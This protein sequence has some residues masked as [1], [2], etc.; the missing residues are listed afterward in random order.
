MQFESEFFKLNLLLAVL[1][2]D[3]YTFGRLPVPQCDISVKDKL[4]PKKEQVISKIHFRICRE[5][6]VTS[7]GFEDDVVYLKDE[8]ANGTFV[9]GKVVGRG[10][11]VVLVN[12]DMIAVAKSN[13]N[14]NDFT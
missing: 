4:P 5:T 3:V 9:N 6:T 13:Y 10:R 7:N 12:N 14:G 11:T 1:T 8:S 2:K